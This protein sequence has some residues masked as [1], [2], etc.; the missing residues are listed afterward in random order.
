[1]T[2]T[3]PTF[4]QADFKGGIVNFGGLGGWGLDDET[5]QNFVKRMAI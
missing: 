2:T 3:R 4:D 1:M 5:H